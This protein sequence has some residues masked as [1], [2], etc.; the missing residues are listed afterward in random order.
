MS[1][2]DSLVRGGELSLL[3]LQR[4]RRGFLSKGCL[5]KETNE[6]CLGLGW[7]TLIVNARKQPLA[8]LWWGGEQLRKMRGTW[9]RRRECSPSTTVEVASWA[10]FVLLVRE[11]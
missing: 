11:W 6:G 9:E 4:G 1:L 8:T 2:P 7:R 5:K 3:G 10:P